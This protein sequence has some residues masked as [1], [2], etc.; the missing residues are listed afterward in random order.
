MMELPPRLRRAVEQA[1]GGIALSDLAVA[2]ASLSQRYRDERREGA[3]YVASEKDALAYL[4]ARFP[5]TY[6]AARASF[7]AIA[8]MRPD[9]APKTALDVGAGP[10]TALLAAAEAWPDLAEALLVEASPIFAALGQRLANAAQGS[11]VTWRAT[12]RIADIAAQDID[13]APRDLVCLAYA[14]N[15]LAAEFRQA[16]LARLWAMTADIL[17]IVE[18]GTPAGWQR[19]LDARRQLIEHGAYVI[20]PCPHAD[21]CPLQSPDWCHFAQRVARSRLHRQAKNAESS[22]EDEKFSYVAVARTPVSRAAARVIAR[23]RKAGGHVTLKLCRPDG[24]AGQTLYS[25][26]D[27]AAFKRAWRS[28]WGSSFR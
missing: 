6:A 5:A 7:A 24:S 16:V 19:I 1:L 2:A 25:R 27:G 3:F 14:L 26:R 17:V 12:W 15:E 20:A 13:S 11:P 28:D 18:P 9:F 23:P 10:G 22:W 4:A 21:P 8:E